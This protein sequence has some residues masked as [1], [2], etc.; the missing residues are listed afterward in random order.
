MG[1][2][3]KPPQAAMRQLLVVDDDRVLRRVLVTLLEAAGFSVAEAA[4]GVSALAQL[5]DRQFDLII[6]DLGLPH[7]SGL[8]ILSEIQKLESPPK[9]IV[10]TA[11][12]TAGAVLQAIRDHAYQYVVKPTPP[13]TIVGLVERVFAAPASRPIEVVSARPDWLELVAPCDLETA[14]RIQ[15]FIER[16][17]ADLPGEMRD[18]IGQAFRELLLNAVEWGGQLD[19]DRTVRIACLRTK[20]MVLYRIA[21]PGP[22]FSPEQLAHAAVS[23]DP[24]QPFGHMRVREEKGIRPGGFGLLMTRTLVDELIYN[25]AHNEVVFVKYL[26]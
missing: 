11:D 24:D 17:D 15:T 4:D 1:F 21:D 26:D 2:I 12:D 25:E 3:V 9:V 13:K 10:V 19:P 14:E 8:Q 16:L 18:S 6:L 20:R 7:I 22:G 5:Q 23:N